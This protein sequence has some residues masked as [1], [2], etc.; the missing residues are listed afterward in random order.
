M[1]FGNIISHVQARVKQTSADSTTRI[2][3]YVNER[4]RAV[5]TGVGLGA[6]RFGTVSLTT[7][8]GTTDYSPATLIHPMTVTYAGGNRVLIEKTKDFFR[9]LD[10]AGTRTGSPQYYATKKFNAA[11]VTIELFPIPDGPPD[12]TLAIDGILT[13]ADLTTNDV[14]VLP[15]DFHDLLVFGATA[16][17]LLKLEKPDQSDRMEKRFRDR[18]SELRYFVAKTAYLDFKQGE[19]GN[20]WWGPW[21]HNYSGFWY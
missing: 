17:E 10:P 7:V 14:P 19:A 13:G 11:T 15:E 6:V 16:D 21:Y 9:N 18:L 1:T 3:Q 5:Q 12:Y 8:A 2:G 4:Y 20:W